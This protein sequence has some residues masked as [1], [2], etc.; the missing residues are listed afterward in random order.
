MKL[1]ARRSRSIRSDLQSPR[2]R[3]LY[4]F[5]SAPDGKV[6]DSPGLKS[7]LSRALGYS[8]DGNFYYDLDYL[9]KHNMLE[10]KNSYLTITNEGKDEFELHSM[11][12]TS[13]FAAIGVGLSM[14]LYYVLLRVGLLSVEGIPVIGAFLIVYGYIVIAIAEKNK[15]KLPVAAEELLEELKTQ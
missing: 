3:L 1:P 2:T 12:D 4:F 11:L 6:K 8:S 9:K 10:G 14:L 15:P 7:K 13:G 5:Y